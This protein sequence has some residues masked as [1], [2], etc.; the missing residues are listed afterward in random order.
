[1]VEDF[2]LLKEMQ[3]KTKKAALRQALDYSFSVQFIR[4][5]EYHWQYRL[6]EGLLD[7]WPSTSKWRYKNKGYTGSPL[8]L[9]FFIWKNKGRGQT[10]SN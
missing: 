10:R 1:M 8:E 5:T 9:D 4:H 7:Y 2:K 3:Q 6:P